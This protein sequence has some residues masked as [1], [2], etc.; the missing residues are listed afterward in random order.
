MNCPH[1]M[2]T[3]GSC[4]ECMEEGNLPVAKWKKVGYPFYGKFDNPCVKCGDSTLGVLVQ[5]YDKGDVTKYPHYEC[6]VPTE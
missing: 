6:G 3:P 5:R 4:F 2:P 1:G